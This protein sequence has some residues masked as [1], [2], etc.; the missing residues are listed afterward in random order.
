M[1]ALLLLLLVFTS[2]GM[3]GQMKISYG[4]EL[5]V[6][7]SGIPIVKEHTADGVY[8][9]ETKNLPVISPVIGFYGEI[10]FGKHFLISSDLSYKKVGYTDNIV[11]YRDYTP[12]ITNET[13][14]EQKFDVVSVPIMLGYNFYLG[15]TQFQIKAG[16]K[17]NYFFNGINIK[18]D[19]YD[20]MILTKTDPFSSK[21]YFAPASHLNNQGSLSLGMNI[22]EKWN[23]SLFSSLGFDIQYYKF[24]Y[25]NWCI[26]YLDN[27]NNFDLGLN[28]KYN[29]GK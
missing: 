24:N 25:Y 28:L 7:M 22:K 17:F 5:G 19:N 9:T 10:Q 29:L 15:S 1:K 18:K 16:Y 6:N 11:R 20:E 12:E 14:V 4:P 8:V 2:F 23:L 3:F 27:Y 21:D 13:Y 26:V